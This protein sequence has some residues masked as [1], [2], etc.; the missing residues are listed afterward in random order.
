MSVFRTAFFAQRLFRHRRAFAGFTAPR[1]PRHPLLRLSV[2]V[3]G[4]A[5]LLA[6]LFVSV[7]VGIAMLA[8]GMLLRVA[9]QRGRPVV[10]R[11]RSLDGDYRVIGKAQLPLAR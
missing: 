3:L 2:G 8:A 6:L 9:R 5:L 11:A 10:P 4:V 1:R 7:F